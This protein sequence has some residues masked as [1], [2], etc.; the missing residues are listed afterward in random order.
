MQENDIKKILE[1]ILE[2]LQDTDFNWRLEGSVNLKIQG[3]N[4][5]IKDLDITTDNNGIDL[6]R[7]KLKDY[8]IKDFYS[9]KIKGNS[10]IC[11]INGFKV[12][13]NSYGDRKLDMFNKTQLINWNSL[14]I[15]ILP[16]NYAKLFY[17]NIGRKD[18]VKLINE[19]LKK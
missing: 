12:E 17:Q 16:L 15:P 6:F 18:K 9:E 11:N 14:Q 8:I 13:I 2:K 1:I 3:V 19:H 10:I 7:K 5:S 4:T